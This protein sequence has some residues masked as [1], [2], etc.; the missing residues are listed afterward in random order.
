MTKNKDESDERAEGINAVE[1]ENLIGA[2]AVVFVRYLIAGLRWAKGEGHKDQQIDPLVEKMLSLMVPHIRKKYEWGQ[3][4]VVAQ[5]LKDL[6][7]IYRMYLDGIIE[8]R[9]DLRE[10][11]KQY[12]GK[13]KVELTP[14][15]FGMLAPDRASISKV[16]GPAQF[17]K[18]AMGRLSNVH[19]KTIHQ[20][21]KEGDRRPPDDF[22][23]HELRFAYGVEVTPQEICAFINKYA[24]FDEDNSIE[25]YRLLT[26]ASDETITALLDGGQ[27][28]TNPDS[29]SASEVSERERIEAYQARKRA[30]GRNRGGPGRPRNTKK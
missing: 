30:S 5:I 16:G 12:M 8:T 29:L 4:W 24:E 2:V 18:H 26:G 1:M 6:R 3:K 27:K 15:Q 9:G 17:A 13:L 23:E 28:V 22:R 21:W 11:L 10:A 19:W 7:T 14:G 20:W 25:T